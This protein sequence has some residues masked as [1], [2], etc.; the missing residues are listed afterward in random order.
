MKRSTAFQSRRIQSVAKGI[1]LICFCIGLP[2]L[3]LEAQEVS[4]D[5]VITRCLATEPFQESTEG[6]GTLFYTANSESA[7]RFDM[8]YRYEVATGNSTSVERNITAVA[9]SQGN[10][11][12][13]TR[14][15]DP[16]YVWPTGQPRST[17]EEATLAR[18]LP[19]FYARV[20]NRQGNLIAE[21]EWLPSWTN[22]L[23]WVN[24]SE[25]LI[26][27]KGFRT[28]LF[29]LNVISG[30]ERSL[31]TLY[32]LSD[33]N[34]LNFWAR[35]DGYG[36]YVAYVGDR[37]Y[38]A[39]HH[40]G[41]GIVSLLDGTLVWA[42][43]SSINAQVA[44]ITGISW[45]PD[46]SKL[47]Y[48]DQ[49]QN[50]NQIRYWSANSRQIE[51]LSTWPDDEENYIDIH[52]L[53]WSPTNDSIAYWRISGTGTNKAARLYIT[54]LETGLTVDYCIS[55]SPS[56]NSLVWSPDGLRMAI[57]SSFAEWPTLILETETGVRHTTEHNLGRWVA[58]LSE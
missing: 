26:G 38:G 19:A 55:A 43:P 18:T 28:N 10:D 6:L 32:T 16:A 8:L 34:P 37:D 45:S 27:Y 49:A 22:S 58:W 56:G 42:G 1:F 57:W 44:H 3:Y 40:I 33:V 13:V 31:V 21:H 14:V 54:S 52:D 12:I 51:T 20:H 30:E 7:D 25:I 4:E 2:G 50:L 48:V 41:L 35:A 11:L 24:N 15:P 5:H 17:E 36:R 39:D 46:G 29:A 23:G 53:T 47:V 9:I